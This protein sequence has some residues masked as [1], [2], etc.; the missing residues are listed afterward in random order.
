M[1]EHEQGVHGVH[2]VQ[3]SLGE[4]HAVPVAANAADSARRAARPVAE[5]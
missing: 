4:H 2:G 1:N 3:W 5:R